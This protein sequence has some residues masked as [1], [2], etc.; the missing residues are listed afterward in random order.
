M[1][2]NKKLKIFDALEEL[3]KMDDLQ[4]IQAW[5]HFDWAYLRSAL[6]EL[7]EYLDKN[8]DVC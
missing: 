2:K 7:K 8:Q 5:K 4:L 6:K 1:T 3:F